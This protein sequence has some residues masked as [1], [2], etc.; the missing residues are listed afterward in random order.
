MN[1]TR[2]GN[3]PTALDAPPETAADAPLTIG[4]AAALMA[5]F[6]FV[7]FRTPP[8]SPMP[9]WC[10]M[11]VLRNA[12]TLTHFDPTLVTYWTFQA[13]Q[14]RQASITTTTPLPIS[15]RLSWGRIEIRDRLGARNGFV[16]LGGE[17]RAERIG[18][19]AV[20]VLFHSAA[21][22]L[23]LPGHSQR[24]DELAQDVAG[25]FA[26]LVPHVWKSRTTEWRVARTP[27]EVLW[28]AFLLDELDRLDASVRA[29][30]E[31]ARPRRQ[32]RSAL[33]EL[34]RERP[35]ALEAARALGN[36]LGL[37]T[38]GRGLR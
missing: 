35:D 4:A 9:E 1:P 8:E 10:L 13:G 37:G 30:D 36:E 28:G 23:R 18:A 33:R 2:V 15:R 17:L 19:D 25:F 24:E 7:A 29:V 31:L 14:G 16:S 6:G 38:P 26:R 32:V 22:I 21:P 5:R 3:R 27:P 12:P 34:A 11:A 20:L